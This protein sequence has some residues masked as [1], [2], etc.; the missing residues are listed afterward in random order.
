MF[1]ILD[2]LT[3]AGV[4]TKINRS[5]TLVPGSHTSQV[6]DFLL[7]Q[8]RPCTE[9]E[10]R[11]ALGILRQSLGAAL[12]RLRKMGLIRRAGVKETPFGHQHVLY[13]VVE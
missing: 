5:E 4:I 2:Q 6:Y 7:E 3:A 9:P 1:S 8:E 11:E 12:H 13:E 10:I